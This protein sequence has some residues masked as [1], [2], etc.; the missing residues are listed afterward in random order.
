M[1]KYHDDA[2]KKFAAKEERWGLTFA[3]GIGYTEPVVQALKN[4]GR[5]LTREKFVA[6]LEKLKNFQGI[7]G[8]INYKAFDP[9][10][11][12]SRLGQREVF[13][14]QATEDGKAKVLTDWIQT[15][16][17]NYE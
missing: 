11:P 7:M 5:D 6:E 14:S 1:K 3:A 16:Y 15:D 17:I 12:T 8:H 2:F 4:C 10:D 13:L 9:N